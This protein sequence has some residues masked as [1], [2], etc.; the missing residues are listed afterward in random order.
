MHEPRDDDH[1]PRTE[2]YYRRPLRA[3]ELLPVIG[4]AVGAGI[5]TF[6]FARM[7]AQRTPLVPREPRAGKGTSERVRDDHRG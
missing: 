7:I 5:V 6:Y 3:A 4:A 2:Y 1:D